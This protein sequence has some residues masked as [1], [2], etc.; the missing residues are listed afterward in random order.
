MVLTQATFKR[1]TN[2]FCETDVSSSRVSADGNLYYV[3]GDK[4]IRVRGHLQTI[5]G[6]DN[7]IVTLSIGR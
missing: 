1:L 4:L 3:G 6:A 2:R 7:A 5:F